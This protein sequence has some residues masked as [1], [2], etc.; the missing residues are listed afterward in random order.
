MGLEQ[1]PEGFQIAEN[2]LEH[3]FVDCVVPRDELAATLSRLIALIAPAD[4]VPSTT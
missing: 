1:L 3:G 2:V 4:P